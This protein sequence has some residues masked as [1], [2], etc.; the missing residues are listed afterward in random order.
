MSNPVRVQL[1]NVLIDFNSPDSE[2]SGCPLLTLK[3][4]AAF[5]SLAFY[6]RHALSVEEKVSAVTAK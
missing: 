6:H 1:I 2:S 5:L 4:S 3:L